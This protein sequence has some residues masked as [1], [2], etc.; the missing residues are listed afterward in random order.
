MSK[1]FGRNQRRAMREKISSLALE[2]TFVEV[3]KKTA[4]NKLH[5]VECELR[6]IKEIIG[7]STILSKHL[8]TVETNYEMEFYNKFPYEQFDTMYFCKKDDPD[9]ML[10]MRS[11]KTLD[12]LKIKAV[13]DHLRLLMHVRLTCGG[14]V[15]GYAL[16]KEALTQIPTDKLIKEV[17][18][19]LGHA[20]KNAS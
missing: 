15:Y 8:D 10:S 18:Y 12:V 2:K 1:R 7:H 9:P 11:F 5:Q 20:L 17:A 3:D 14:K 6:E 4:L 16:T 19:Q 13:I